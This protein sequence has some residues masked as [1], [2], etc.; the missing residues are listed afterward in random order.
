MTEKLRADMTSRIK[1][2]PCVVASKA[3]K[4][5]VKLEPGTSKV[6]EVIDLS[7]DNEEVSCHII[8]FHIRNGHQFTSWLYCI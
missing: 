7:S 1:I 5:E 6:T 8:F 4:Q 3:I 2:E